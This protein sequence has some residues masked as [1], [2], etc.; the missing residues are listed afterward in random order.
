V[1]QSLQT[2]ANP[3]DLSHAIHLIKID[4]M[5]RLVINGNVHELVSDLIT[6]GR[7]PDNTIVIGD[8]S[9]SSHHAQLQLSGETYR[10]KDLGSTNGTRVNGIPVTE[11][12]LQ[13]GD[14]IRFGA[15]EARYE[16]DAIRSQLTPKA[17]EDEA[18]SAKLKAVPAGF[19]NLSSFQR[20]KNQEIAVRTVIFAG[21]AVILLIF[22]GSMIAV[23][24]MHPPPP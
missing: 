8:S 2:F 7:D 11:T 21:L 18:T 9:V 10:L 4:N 20:Q 17:R 3:S 12:T 23:L 6:I 13:F 5:P 24:L 14:Q 22:L 15:A 19:A 16:G 1:G